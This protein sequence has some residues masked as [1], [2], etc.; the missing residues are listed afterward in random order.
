MVM[1][2]IFSGNKHKLK[3]L[4]HNGTIHIKITAIALFFFLIHSPAVLCQKGIL[5]SLFTFRSGIVRTD[6]ALKIITSATGYNFTFDSRLVDAGNRVAMNFSDARL[7]DVL[8]NI[9]NND[10]LVYSVIDRYIIISRIIS[11][12][13]GTTDTIAIPEK[14]GRYITGLVIDGETREP[15]PSATVALIGK[16]RGTVANFNGEFGLM[17]TPDCIDDTLVVSY[18]GYYGRKIPVRYTLGNDF[19]IALRSEFISIPEIIIRNQIP[20]EIILKSV[21]AIPDNYG[22]TPARMTAFYRE[23]VMKRKE[24]QTY[25]EAILQIYKSPYTSA[26]LNDQIKVFRSRKI[27]NINRS[28]TLAVRLKAG[29]STTLELDGIRN[30]FDFMN[31]QEMGD[32]TY[33]MTD[34]VTFDEESAFVIEFTQKESVD[35]PLYKGTLYINSFDYALLRAE[36]EINPALINK[37]RNSF[38]S[39]PSRGYTTW[40]TSVRYSVNYRKHNN[41]YFL[42]HVRGDLEFASRQRKRLFSTQFRVFF[43]LAVTDVNLDNVTRFDREELAPVHAVFSKTI[44]SYDAEF[45]GSQDFLKPED[46]LLQ[47]LSNMNVRLQEFSE[48]RD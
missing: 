38:V 40:P 28:D 31:W 30:S 39:S 14:G 45:W 16:G 35:L 7:S 29:L 8:D 32:Y 17:I 2:T 25:S 36:F 21:A 18:L 47:A 13:T 46:N 22:N 23:G 34:I 44:T 5:D 20:Q 15:L 12:Y 48:P 19:T 43:E 11:P 1:F 9:L 6:N 37:I 24:L 10:S 27:E 3:K 41:R 4:R 42:N 26:L 33:M